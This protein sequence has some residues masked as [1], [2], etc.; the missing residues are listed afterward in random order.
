LN[1]A[2]MLGVVALKAEQPIHWDAAAGRV[3]NVDSANAYL[4]RKYRAGWEL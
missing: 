1:E 3:T 4:T 2:M